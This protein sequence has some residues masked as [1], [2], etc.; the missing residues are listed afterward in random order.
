M[1]GL[2]R[3]LQD[4]SFPHLLQ[5]PHR[6][7]KAILLEI[8]RFLYKLI[9]PDYRN[10]GVSLEREFTVLLRELDYPFL[11]QLVPK[12]EGPY[13]HYEDY[14]ADVLDALIYMAGI[15]S[16]NESLPDAAGIDEPDEEVRYLHLVESWIFYNY[17]SEVY[18]DN[19]QLEEVI[20]EEAH[21]LDKYHEVLQKDRSRL[22]ADVEHLRELKLERQ[23]RMDQ[24]QQT[25]NDHSFY[26]TDLMHINTYM[27]K[28]EQNTPQL[29]ERIESSTKTL[30]S[31]EEE[32]ASLAVTRDRYRTILAESGFETSLLDEYS[33]QI[34]RLEKD[35]TK[36]RTK[37]DS[38]ESALKS[39]QTQFESR[40]ELVTLKIKEISDRQLM[41]IT[42]KTL[43][44]LIKE[45]EHD[46]KTLENQLK[47]VQRTCDLLR[48]NIET[49]REAVAAMEKTI[50]E[51]QEQQVNTR[52]EIYTLQNKKELALK[53]AQVEQIQLR[54]DLNKKVKDSEV[55]LSNAKRELAVAEDQEVSLT[56]SIE[57]QLEHV[58]QTVSRKFNE[59]RTF[60]SSIETTFA[61]LEQ[62]TNDYK[63]K[64]ATYRAKASTF[65]AELDLTITME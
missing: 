14:W 26:R 59:L 36:L 52:D 8:I 33:S 55:A 57:T 20:K 12:L 11:G 32:I 19:P 44:K 64:I 46:Q 16:F 18:P 5:S 60:S 34:T 6:P 7:Q 63:S 13:S 40:N 31:L 45:Y 41:E 47:Q 2:Y 51:E 4:H 21:T 30:E 29:R 43:E 17:V 49:Q 50:S 65:Q 22:E 9:E 3:F 39:T 27:E 35:R 37:V 62:E 23:T 28:A 54:K 1:G 24:F 58:K 10:M 15:I 48:S 38:A 42:G 56:K 53:D 61:H 25:D